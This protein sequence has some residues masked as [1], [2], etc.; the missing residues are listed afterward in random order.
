MHS[1]YGLA[2]VVLFFGAGALVVG[3]VRAAEALPV[4]LVP[5]VGVPW[6]CC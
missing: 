2:F 4:A 5:L 3:D 6:R 1:S